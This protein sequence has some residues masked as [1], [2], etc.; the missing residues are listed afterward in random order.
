MRGSRRTLLRSWSAPSCGLLRLWGGQVCPEFT[1]RKTAR[2][3][4][5]KRG[6]RGSLRWLLLGLHRSRRVT[7][8]LLELHGAWWR[9]RKRWTRW[10][11]RAGRKRPGPRWLLRRGCCQARC[12]DDGATEG[13]YRF[14]VMRGHDRH[15]WRLLRLGR[16]R[17]G[18]ECRR[19]GAGGWP[20]SGSRRGRR[21]RPR[22]RVRCP[23][24][25]RTWRRHGS[26]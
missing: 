15:G 20:W 4:G 19:G 23:S 9:C 6:F 2:S 16:G 10:P 18:A 26:R 8:L 5:S 25:G 21:W 22:W 13:I 11:R 17:Y 24:A 1:G 3:R 14:L 7:A 12:G